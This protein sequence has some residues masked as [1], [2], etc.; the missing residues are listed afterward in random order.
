MPDGIKV[1]PEI[2]SL[3]VGQNETS[4]KVSVS[5]KVVAGTYYIK[6]V[7]TGDS[8]PVTYGPIKN[9]VITVVTGIKRTVTP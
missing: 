1:S 5:I 6:W 3:D 8:T 4:F 9:T 2:V 7:K